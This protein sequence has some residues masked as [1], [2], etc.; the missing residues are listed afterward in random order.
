MGGGRRGNPRGTRRIRC[1]ASTGRGEPAAR[2]TR[3]RDKKPRRRLTRFAARRLRRAG[4]HVVDHAGHG[5]FPPPLRGNVRTRPPARRPGGRAAGPE[6]L[7]RRAVEHRHER[8]VGAVG[9][10]ELAALE[11]GRRRERPSPRRPRGSRRPRRQEHP[12]ARASEPGPRPPR[13]SVRR[14][15]APGNASTVGPT[16]SRIVVDPPR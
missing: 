7:R 11:P 16:S 10:G 8:R 15:T 12:P 13:G 5:P 1:E 4:A 9:G 14:R 6:T 3:R 2:R